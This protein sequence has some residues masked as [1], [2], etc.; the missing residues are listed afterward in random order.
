MVT[1]CD[2]PFTFTKLTA[3]NRGNVTREQDVVIATV[4]MA[5]QL[6]VIPNITLLS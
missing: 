2:M 3:H 4:V 5:M 6:Q 1:T